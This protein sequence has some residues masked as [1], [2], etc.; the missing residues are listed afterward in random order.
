MTPKVN[1][2]EKSTISI[3]F[4]KILFNTFLLRKK[5]QKKR[6]LN[7]LKGLKPLNNDVNYFFALFSK[8]LRNETTNLTE[9]YHSPAKQDCVAVAI[10]T[11]EGETKLIDNIG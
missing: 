1:L 7:T 11:L 4:S 6:G 9:A 2:A 3:L 5:K 10:L 8:R